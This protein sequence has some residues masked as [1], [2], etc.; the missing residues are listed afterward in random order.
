MAT[1]PI[2]DAGQARQAEKLLTPPLLQYPLRAFLHGL[3]DA[4]GPDSSLRKAMFLAVLWETGDEGITPNN[5]ESCLPPSVRPTQSTISRMIR[6]LSKVG[7]VESFLCED[8]Q[9]RLVRLTRLGRA[10]LGSLSESRRGT[11]EEPT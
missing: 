5:L 4:L 9:T 6:A 3:C 11:R 7:I 2:N 1:G 8:G 10:L